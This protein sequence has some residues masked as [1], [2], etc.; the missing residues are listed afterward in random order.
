MV[1]F[2]SIS[3]WNSSLHERELL[4]KQTDNQFTEPHVR[5]QTC[6]RMEIYSG[7]G[8]IPE[9]VTRHLF[10]V[11]S[12]LESSLPGE[13]AI[14]GQVK[15]A[16]ETARKQ[17][18]LSPDLHRL[19]QQALR[20]GKRV[21]TE[22]GIGIGAVS[23]GQATVEIIL[24]SGIEL[25]EAQITLIGVNK[26]T[27]DIIRFLRSRGAKAIFLAN[28]SYQKAL[29]LAK[30]YGCDITGFDQLTEVLGYTNVLISATSAPH[31]ILKK[32]QFA[33]TK[34]MMVF[35]LAFP[36]D[37]DPAVAGLSQ[38]NLFNLE[39]VEAFVRKNI[40]QREQEVNHANRII[41][42]Q[43]VQFYHLLPNKWAKSS[44][45]SEFQSLSAG[46]RTDGNNQSN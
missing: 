5:L 4:L 44:L 10:R 45:S 2:K 39:D 19:F 28:R 33:E 1:F 42:E 40:C 23:H 27:G 17:F 16:Y 3:C 6:N 18:D 8:D 30:R 24:Q 11:V 21:R 35:D 25:K 41:E 31:L 37:I 22:S 43:I 32:E 20:V 7:E 9:E 34:S 46:I 26:L 36:R 38:V 15:V 13:S 29:P 12:G 14:Q